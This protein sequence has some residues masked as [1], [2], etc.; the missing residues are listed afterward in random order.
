MGGLSVTR[1]TLLTSSLWTELQEVLGLVT[2]VDEKSTTSAPMEGMVASPFHEGWAPIPSDAWYSDGSNRGQPAVWTAVAIQPETDTIWFDTGAGWSSQWA[3]LRAMW[4]M[5]ANEALPLT[6]CTDSW[7]VF[8]GLTL[9]IST[10]HANK[11]MV[12][13]R[14]LSGQVYGKAYGN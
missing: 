1:S 3:E 2:H 6:I 4:L 14:P 12:I 13:H 8:W 5:A 7:A 9:W 11:W 10:W